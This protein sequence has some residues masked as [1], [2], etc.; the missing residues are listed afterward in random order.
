MKYKFGD[1]VQ[2]YNNNKK[3]YVFPISDE[4]YMFI[5]ESAFNEENRGSI[6]TAPYRLICDANIR[7]IL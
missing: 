4:T 6:N 2:L 3:G 1:K 5:E 7:T